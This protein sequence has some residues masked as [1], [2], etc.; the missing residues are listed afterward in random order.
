MSGSGEHARAAPMRPRY[1]AVIIGSGLGGATLALRLAER[2]LQVLVVER[3]AAAT[4]QAGTPPGDDSVFVDRLAG[5]TSAISVVGGAS[6]F[7]GAALYRLRE[8]DF[9]EVAHEAGTSPAWPISYADLAPYYDQAEALYRVHGAPDGDPSEPPRA[10]PFPYP[11]IPHDPLIARMVQRLEQGG[12]RVAPVPKGLDYGPGGRCV[13][14]AGCDAYSCT[15]D[16]KMDADTAALRPALATGNVHLATR[17]SCLR[18]LTDSDGGRA[19]GVELLR[20]GESVR[21]EAEVV[22]VCAGL[23][24]TPALLRASRTARHPEG[25]GNARGALGRYLA[26]HSVGTVF[27]LM[28]VRRVPSVHSKTFAINTFYEGAADWPYPLGVIQI[29]GQMPYWERTLRAVR[30]LAKIVGTH[31]FLCFYMVEAVPT[32]EAG[33]RFEGDRVAGTIEPPHSMGSFRKLRALTIEAFHRA[34]YRTVARVRHP[35]FWHPVGTAR[36]GADPATSVLDPNCQVHD[37]AGLYVVDACT[38]PTAGAV[39]TALTIIALALRAGDHIAA[40]RA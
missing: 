22:A 2:G 31:G 27:P 26:G 14:C 28:G 30:P 39:N 17:T 29:A 25:L 20:D 7:Y 36:F 12:A 4:P 40:A 34:G 5:G 23:N 38:M 15:L 24:E 1:D 35:L 37:I 3:G 10:G 11:P 16:A 9:R 21:V 8:S 19:T 32:R 13:L 33:L 6:K 18:V